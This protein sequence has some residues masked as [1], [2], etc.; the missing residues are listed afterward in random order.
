MWEALE[1]ANLKVREPSLVQETAKAGNR[2]QKVNKKQNLVIL[3]SLG[4]NWS[5]RCKN[6]FYFNFFQGQIVCT[7]ENGVVYMVALP[8]DEAAIERDKKVT[9]ALI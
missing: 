6:A 3:E 2:K 7:E 5:C 1:A 9:P 8:A 4:L